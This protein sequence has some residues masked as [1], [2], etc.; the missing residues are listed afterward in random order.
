[1]PPGAV[2][3]DPVTLPGKGK[4]GEEGWVPPRASLLIWKGAGP[5][6]SLQAELGC[7]A[8]AAGAER[9]S[10]AK[11]CDI[12][13]AAA[14]SGEGAEG[15]QLGGGRAGRDRRG[16]GRQGPSAGTAQPAAGTRGTRR[17]AGGRAGAKALGGLGAAAEHGVRVPHRTGGSVNGGSASSNLSPRLKIA[18][19]LPTA[20]RPS[21]LQPAR[22][23]HRTRQ[24]LGWGLPL[25]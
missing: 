8:G 15:A 9:G 14:T 16:G 6:L 10:L 11:E 19:R 7:R 25:L 21:G 22:G 23:R 13:E 4:G 24:H 12:S 18:S 5:F 17:R 3:P 2:R 1:M 20:L